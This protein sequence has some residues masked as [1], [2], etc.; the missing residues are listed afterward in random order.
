MDLKGKLCEMNIVQ[1][2]GIVHCFNKSGDMLIDQFSGKEI[3]IQ[4][5]NAQ[6][7]LVGIMPEIDLNIEL[8]NCSLQCS[9]MSY[10]QRSLD[11][12]S[13]KEPIKSPPALTVVSKNN[14][15]T[16][17]TT[18]NASTFKIKANYSKILLN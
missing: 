13:Y 9:N 10:Q 3:Q 2:K 4:N 15:Y 7:K 5:S 17:L 6:I 18:K 11:I 8:N 14:Y 16:I 1:S 12:S